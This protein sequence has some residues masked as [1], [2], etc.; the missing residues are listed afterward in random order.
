MRA[1]MANRPQFPGWP[2]PQPGPG[3]VF[4]G[5]GVPFPQHP[6]RPSASGML[7]FP[8]PG[9]VAAP[10][11]PG[12]VAYRSVYPPSAAR[13]PGFNNS[14]QAWSGYPWGPPVTLASPRATSPNIV[15]SQ[16]QGFAPGLGYG[17]QGNNV[18]GGFTSQAQGQIGI[19]AQQALYV[20][21]CDSR[22][23]SV[24]LGQSLSAGVLRS[25]N[26]FPNSAVQP[27]FMDWV[28]EDSASAQL[29][30]DS[31]HRGWS[32]EA[33]SVPK[34][35]DLYRLVDR[36][37]D[38]I[39]K[40]L[41][42][43]D[44]QTLASATELGVCPFN[45]HHV[46][47]AEALFRHTLQCP[48]S[49]RGTVEASSLLEYLQYPHTVDLDPIKPF[50]HDERVANLHPG[51]ESSSTNATLSFENT[52]MLNVNYTPSKRLDLV[53]TKQ[54]S[55]YVDT[56]NLSEIPRVKAN[57]GTN[58]LIEKLECRTLT[59]HTARQQFDPRGSL[60]S[61]GEAPGV[62]MTSSAHYS[63]KSFDDLISSMPN[64]LRVELEKCPYVV[65]K[66]I[67]NLEAKARRIV[68]P[69]TT[70]EN[71]GAE[72]HI[73]AEE[74]KE[75][76]S[77][78]VVEGSMSAK[79]SGATDS[80]ADGSLNRIQHI[81]ELV[82]TAS[83]GILPSLHWNLVKELE[84]WKNMP[85]RCSRTVLQAATCFGRVRKGLIVE[86]LLTHSPEYGVVLDMAMAAHV[87]CLVQLYLKALRT[88]SLLLFEHSFAK[89]L[90]KRDT[91]ISIDNTVLECPVYAEAS[92]WLASWLSHLY[93]PIN[94][95]AV[96]RDILKHC[97]N[98]CGRILSVFHIYLHSQQGGFKTRGKTAD[99][100]GASDEES[101]VFVEHN[102]MLSEGVDDI[103]GV[104]QV[105]AAIDA[106]CERANFE[107]YIKSW[108]SINNATKPQR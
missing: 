67:G 77:H 103:L 101:N 88:Q 45:P 57:V 16:V 40:I 66:I 17:A 29:S 54:E 91:P 2:A 38:T 90:N 30:G 21:G 14:V 92:T 37:E 12:H 83:V 26:L 62:V 34:S 4:G 60:F 106:V 28:D 64:F 108:M 59:L 96:V 19:H 46:V 5:P 82:E 95:E 44:L 68:L 81:F 71:P 33:S 79:R 20:P 63:S 24:V 41:Y 51:A 52:A 8:P 18:S 58:N 86:W 47:P 105:G 32:L 49:L 3:S 11:L 73:T 48:S 65:P 27:L 94:S 43:T 72:N 50:T 56:E 89:G 100:K 9:F 102:K 55:G 85:S 22:G 93:G 69:S 10:G 53:I 104:N 76:E 107:R 35:S 42:L 25:N 80:E 84:T 13:G 75:Q 15:H 87:S 6:P 99:V 39:G 7:Q 36:V 70:V 97:L 78:G 61:Y 98:S 74:E 23:G 1:E 31:G